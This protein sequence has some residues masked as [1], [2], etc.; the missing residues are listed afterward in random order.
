MER[1]NNYLIQASQ[2]K[3]RF[4]TYD[5]Q[6]LIDKFR[7]KSDEAHIYVNLLW[8]EYRIHRVSGDMEFLTQ[9]V[10]YDGNSYDE[11]MTLLDLLC[12]SRDDRRCAGR[13]LLRPDLLP[14]QLRRRTGPHRPVDSGSSGKVPNC[15]CPFWR[16]HPRRRVWFFL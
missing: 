2:A 7:L 14:E 15:L 11:V 4:L 13:G 12:D 6:K 5:Q 3:A 10:W 1:V 16:A 8:K 9:G